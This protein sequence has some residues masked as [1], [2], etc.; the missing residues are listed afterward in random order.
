MVG[1]FFYNLLKV[2]LN[3]IRWFGF[4]LLNFIRFTVDVVIIVII[5]RRK[6]E[7]LNKS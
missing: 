4:L 7:L 2:N 6:Y 1:I 5:Y 3:V